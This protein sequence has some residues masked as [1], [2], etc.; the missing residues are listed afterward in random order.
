MGEEENWFSTSRVQPVNF[1]TLAS[2]HLGITEIEAVLRAGIFVGGRLLDETVQDLAL[3]SDAMLNLANET[4]LLALARFQRRVAY[5]NLGSDTWVRACSG[6]ILPCLPDLDEIPQRIPQ[7]IGDL[8]VICSAALQSA[9]LHS[10][11][12]ARHADVRQM[13]T[14]LCTLSWERYVVHFT[15]NAHVKICNHGAEDTENEGVN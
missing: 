11:P 1:V 3:N 8:P 15:G 5:A 13:L 10:F 12:K 2:P 14:N 7:E 9:P 4:A 6:L